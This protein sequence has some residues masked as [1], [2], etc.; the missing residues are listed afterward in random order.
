MWI[1]CDLH[2]MDVIALVA[3]G[4]E[5]VCHVYVPLPMCMHIRHANG[6]HNHIID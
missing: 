4:C 5:H 1:T 3:I 6:K 2:I